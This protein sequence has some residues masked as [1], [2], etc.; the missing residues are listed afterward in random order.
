M[1]E[2]VVAL[3]IGTGKDL[4]RKKSRKVALKVRQ[5]EAMW[6]LCPQNLQ[7]HLTAAPRT[8]NPCLVG[9]IQ[10]P[11]TANNGAK[12]EKTRLEVWLRPLTRFRTRNHRRRRV[13]FVFLKGGTTDAG[14]KAPKGT[15]RIRTSLVAKQFFSRRLKIYMQQRQEAR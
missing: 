6:A 4:Q 9:Q 5:S 1:A 11:K 12:I 10:P 14:L 8:T 7:S 2:P 3:L 13:K 15:P